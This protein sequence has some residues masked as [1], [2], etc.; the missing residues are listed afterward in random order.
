MVL[1]L[2]KMKKNTGVLCGFCAERNKEGK[3]ESCVCKNWGDREIDK[4]G[5]GDN[6]TVVW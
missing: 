5:K 4:Q 1:N 3:R 2:T 6:R